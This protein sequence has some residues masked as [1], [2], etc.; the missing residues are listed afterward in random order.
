M[1]RFSVTVDAMIVLSVAPCNQE[2]V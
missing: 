2:P 1:P